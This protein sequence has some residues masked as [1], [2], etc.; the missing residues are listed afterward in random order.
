LTTGQDVAE[1]VQKDD[2]EDRE[3]FG[4][5]PDNRRIF[6]GTDVD[7]EIGRNQPRP[8]QPDVDTP[9]AKET[10]RSLLDLRGWSRHV[11][12]CGNA[13]RRNPTRDCSAHRKPPR[14][15]EPWTY[16]LRKRRSTN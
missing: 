1:F 4:G 10:P 13:K 11:L 12:S 3:I 15:L 8:V 14:G 9:D 16:A 7:F 5:V 6:R 2:P